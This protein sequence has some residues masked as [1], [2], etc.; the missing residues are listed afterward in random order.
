MVGVATALLILAQAWL[1][2][3]GVSS[4][5]AAH[6]LDGVAM[7][8]G[9]LAAVFCGRACLAWLQESLAHQASASVK[10]QLRR[11]ILQA[12]LS[13]PTDATMPSGTL[14][15][16]MTTG[17]DALDGYYS[18]YLPQLV[19]AVI[20]PAVLATAIG[21]N[22]LT[23]LVI[24]VVTIPLIPV[25]M[26]LIGWRTEAAVAK[27]FKVATRL[28]NHFADLVAGLPTLQVFGR[29]RAQLEGLRRTEAANR[30]ET[31]RTL[32]I[33]FLSSFI[34]ELLATL[35]VA[36]VAVTVGF[37]VAAGGMDLRTSLFILIL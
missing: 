34:L 17:L 26:A 1:L 24:V 35:S 16:L 8:C 37:R 14:I 18:K 23:S 36:L 25:F 6:H 31:M 21:L 20:V 11:D 3:R 4:V 15:S 12:R 22:D 7:W 27:R 19:L 28:A 9:L 2:S 10:S 5:F 30:S 33:S 32:R 13:R 29:A